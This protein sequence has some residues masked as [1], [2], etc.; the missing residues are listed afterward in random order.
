M[1]DKLKGVRDSWGKGLTDLFAS[2]SIDED[3][4]EKLEEE[5]LLGDVGVETAEALLS[6]MRD[7]ARM[8]RIVSPSDLKRAFADLLI[9]RLETVEGM[10]Q[11]LRLTRTPCVVLLVGVNGSGKTTTAGK[12]ACQYKKAGKA[13]ILAAADTYRAAAIEQLQLWG[14]RAGVRVVA[15]NQGSD[16]AAVVFDAIQ[17]AKASGADL[18]IVDTAGR[19]H[20][21]SNLMDELKKV[22]RI[23]SR[24]IEGGPSESLLVLDA[25]TGQNGFLQAEAFNKAFPLTGVILSK[26]DN[27]AKGGVLISVVE[28]LGLPIRYVGVGEEVE[29][30]ELFSP[31][32]FIYALLGLDEVDEEGEE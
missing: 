23:V 24:E 20:T 14:Q 8:H 5:L 30:L 4:W 31:K 19:L 27:T 17:A 32:A 9:S 12:L 2:S 10:G 18:V 26:F 15:Q 13:V 29:D 22:H 25:V 6:Q 3:F 28:K 21:K 7:Y 1:V 11:P 16:P